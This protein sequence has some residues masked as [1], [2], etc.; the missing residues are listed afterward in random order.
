MASPSVGNTDATTPVAL[1]T[2]AASG[3]GH[4]VATRFLDAGWTVLG[5][6]LREPQLDA[7][8]GTLLPWAPVDVCDR[9]AV[10]EAVQHRPVGA[11]PLRAVLNVAGIYPPTTLGDLS[12]E[13]YRAIF[14]TNVLGTLNVTAESVEV[15]RSEG[16]GGAIVNFASVDAFALSPGQLIYSAA[17]AAVVSL[18]RSLAVE[19]AADD[20][21]VNAVAPGWVDTPG[22]RATGRMEGAAAT[23]P[24]GRVGRP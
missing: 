5:L 17:K 15:M 16:G 4:A 18:T 3:M 22:N 12:L 24:L 6:D 13:R 11:G 9:A 20:I 14:D 19:L 7:S 10:R 21:T 23:I 2:G 1:V 8:R